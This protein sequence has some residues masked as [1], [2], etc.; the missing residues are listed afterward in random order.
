MSSSTSLLPTSQQSRNDGASQSKYIALLDG[1]YGGSHADLAAFDTVVL[2][3]GSTGITFTLP[4]LLDIAERASIGNLPVKRLEFIWI[5]KSMSWTAWVKDE[6]A[7]AVEKVKAAGIEIAVRIFVTCDDS[8]TN[9]TSEAN[10]KECG[11]ECDKSL[12][13]CCCTTV[14]DEE[15]KEET[16]VTDNIMPT[17]TAQKTTTAKN[18]S[19]TSSVSEKKLTT[20]SS[21]ATFTSGRPS[22]QPILW[23]LA[24]QAEGEMG[25]ATCGP[26]GL[27]TGIR[28]T[29]A[30]ISD[31]RAVHKGTGAQGIY[32]HVES[33]CW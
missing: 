19:Q 2:I 3:A 17:K 27:S 24:D 14:D 15:V 22:F 9:G 21:L 25:I 11:C 33:F 4:Q 8:I 18:T 32:L 28:N 6:L 5:I 31:E 20:L 13:P 29:V 16:K 26:M 23:D 10:E 7:S 12:G 30:K 1:P